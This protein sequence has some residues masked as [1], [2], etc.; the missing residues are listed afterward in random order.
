MVAHVA[1]VL[2]AAVDEVVAV[3]SADL[4]L[5]PLPARV[6]R[7][8]EPGL[9]PLAGIREG[10]EAS[11]HELLFV[12]AVDAPFLTADFVRWMLGAGRAAAP[13]VDGVVNPTAAVFPRSAAPVAARLLRSPGAGA[14]ALLEAVGFEC[15]PASEY[16]DL[17]QNLNTPSEYL[18]A[19]AR[20]PD[21]RP[22]TVETAGRSV[23]VEPGLL[24]EALRSAGASPAGRLLL[25]G[26]PAE[27]RDDLPL[28]PGD[29]VSIED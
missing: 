28:G 1:D 18:A 9:G 10:L 14:V 2:R 13:E 27:R 8:R 24:K 23:Q 19:L 16:A 4:D 21:S 22:V 12:A 17:L 15:R 29:R 26:R 7:D 5:P 20:V 25:N 3:A 6:V 11:R